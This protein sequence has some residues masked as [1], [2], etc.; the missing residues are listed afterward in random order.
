MIT[1]ENSAL[2]GF[3][4]MAAIVLAILVMIGCIVSKHG[5]FI[6]ASVINM[7]FVAGASVYLFKNWSK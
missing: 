7:I 2:K 4:L 3:T 1:G 6:V 5:F